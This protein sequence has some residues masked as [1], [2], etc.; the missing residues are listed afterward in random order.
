MGLKSGFTELALLNFEEKVSYRPIGLVYS[1][2]INVKPKW[3]YN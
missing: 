2:K 1:K 3:I